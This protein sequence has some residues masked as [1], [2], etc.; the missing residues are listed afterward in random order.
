MASEQHNPYGSSAPPQAST[1]SCGSVSPANVSFSYGSVVYPTGLAGRAGSG[2]VSSTPPTQSPS[3]APLSQASLGAQAMMGT[4]PRMRRPMNLG[5]LEQELLLD[6]A[7]P[8]QQHQFQQH[9]HAQL[10]SYQHGQPGCGAG[11]TGIM[12]TVPSS[13]AQ[14]ASLSASSSALGGSTQQAVGNLATRGDQQA[15]EVSAFSSGSGQEKMLYGHHSSS[16]LANENYIA[17]MSS[18]SELTSGARGHHRRPYG[19]QSRVYHAHPAPRVNAASSHTSSRLSHYSDSASASYSAAKQM[20]SSLSLASQAQQVDQSLS[21]TRFQAQAS[22][23]GR[24]LPARPGFKQSISIDQHQQAHLLGRLGSPAHLSSQPGQLGQYEL[25]SPGSA[26][27]ADVAQTGGAPSHLNQQQQQRWLS[28]VDNRYPAARGPTE[29]ELVEAQAANLS[30]YV[31]RDSGVDKGRQMGPHLPAGACPMSLDQQQL[32]MHA[33]QHLRQ[34]SPINQHQSAGKYDAYEGQQSA[35]RQHS[36]AQLDLLAAHKVSSVPSQQSSWLLPGAQHLSAAGQ[37][38]QGQRQPAGRLSQAHF[39]QAMSID[40]YASSGGHHYSPVGYR[41]PSL[42]ANFDERYRP[43]LGPLISG[44]YQQGD[45]HQD[46]G[47]SASNEYLSGAHAVLNQDNFDSVQQAQTATEH[48]SQLVLN[49][50]ASSAGL[51]MNNYNNLPPPVSLNNRQAIVGSQT[52]KL[53]HQFSSSSSGGANSQSGSLRSSN[54]ELNKQTPPDAVQKLLNSG[55]NNAAHQANNNNSNSSS[56]SAAANNNS[57][58]NSQPPLTSHQSPHNTSRHD[59]LQHHHQRGVLKKGYT[60]STVSSSLAG[61]LT[62]LNEPGDLS[63]TQATNSAF[64][65]IQSGKRVSQFLI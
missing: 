30:L 62:A 21:S 19:S 22:G 58:T 47:S 52:G 13:A 45:E 3:S 4:N 20:S 60:A 57:T 11:G 27:G 1:S 39:K 40:H 17:G 23:S 18:D 25:G 54:L 55:A 9:P 14:T 64:G 6:A 49:S 26:G 38:S 34:Q 16:Y 63:P 50:P 12:T 32:Q 43:G 7:K 44:Y 29:L 48:Q 15:P 31:G 46:Y 42:A 5:Q 10:R 24:Q 56:S 35:V 41:T 59:H 28:N 51:Q 8:G 37:A 2:E 61:S 33:K 36:R 65:P 53:Q